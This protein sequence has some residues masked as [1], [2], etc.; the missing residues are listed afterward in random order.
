MS[1]PLFHLMD[2]ICDPENLVL[3]Y[4]S[5]IKGKRTRAEVLEYSRDLE[6]NL[7]D[8]R[9][10]LL[11]GSYRVGPYH[12]FYVTLPKT[13]LIMA[14]GFRDRVVQWA[15]YR[16]LNP[17][18]DKRLIED[19][20]GCRTGKGTLRAAER[21]HGWTREIRRKPDYDS[22]YCLKL[23]ISKFFY[24]VDHEAMMQMMKEICPE[25]DFLHLMDTIINNPDVPF[26][27]P[28]GI[29]AHDCPVEDRLFDV[30]M[31]IGNLSSQM[32]ANLY[33]DPL[34]KYC[35]HELR[36]HYYA[37]YMDDIIIMDNDLNRLHEW[38]AKIE[39]FLKERLK[40]DLNNKTAIHK[41]KAGIDFVGYMIHPSG[42]R[43]RKHT[44]RHMKRALLHV[45]KMYAEGKIELESALDTLNS[46]FG[47]LKHCDSYHIRKW[48]AEHISFK[49]N[50]VFAPNDY[51]DIAYIERDDWQ[52]YFNIAEDD[53]YGLSF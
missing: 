3:A 1:K 12:Q 24:R 52:E 23:D 25:P 51:P 10:D 16:Q 26:G 18:I 47:M 15:L 34:D 9:R 29:K 21:V 30:G 50:T 8:L 48:I 38:K 49:R 53:D 35:K 41:V 17:Y 19:T 27:L 37:R 31:P 33:L 7:D 42:I 6:R 13:R 20:F 32:I 28:A 2:A 39:A 11:D 4:R 46:Y 36:I 14:L 5:A 22:W 45:S 43:I 40:L 44:K